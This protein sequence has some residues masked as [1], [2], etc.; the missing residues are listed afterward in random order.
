MN[1]IDQ[2]CRERE[3][4]E[5]DRAAAQLC[6]LDG[7]MF[8]MSFHMNSASTHDRRA[9]EMAQR[10]LNQYPDNHPGWDR[11]LK[12]IAEQDLDGER[13]DFIDQ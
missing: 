12:D 7:N 5:Q 6:L 3:L 2:I 4:A 8:G 1:Q 11:L 13:F 9:D 10:M